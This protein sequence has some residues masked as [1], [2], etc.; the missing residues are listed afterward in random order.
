MGKTSRK[1]NIVVVPP[2]SEW[3]EVEKLGEQGHHIIKLDKA[4][5]CCDPKDIDL[6]LGPICWL[7]DSAHKKY[8]PLALKAARLK[9]YGSPKKKKGESD[10]EPDL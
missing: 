6:I 2:V 1:L 3:P 10:E 5:P 7:M 4:G 8:L 9:R